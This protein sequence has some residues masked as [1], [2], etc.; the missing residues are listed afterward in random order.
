MNLRGRHA[1]CLELVPGRLPRVKE[2]VAQPAGRGHPVDRRIVPRGPRPVEKPPSEVGGWR[3]SHLET[4]PN[5]GANLVTTRPDRRA[6]G[7]DEVGRMAAALARERVDRH[8]GNA[9]SETTP[10]RVRSRNGSRAPVGDQ[11]GHTV[12]RLHGNGGEGIVAENN[13][14]VR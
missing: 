13:V 12:G 1:G 11:Q 5:I 9:A 3:P 2:P 8:A 4:M 14:R 7:G 10:A 6:D